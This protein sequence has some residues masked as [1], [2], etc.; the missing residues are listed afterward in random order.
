VVGDGGTFFDEGD[1]CALE[2]VGLTLDSLDMDMKT[3][4][5]YFMYYRTA[6]SP[7]E[8]LFIL[9]PTDG[10]ELSEGALRVEAIGESLGADILTTFATLPLSDVVYSRAGAEYQLSRRADPE[11]IKLLTSLVGETKVGEVPLTAENDMITGG[12]VGSTRRM[13]LSQTRNKW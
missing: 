6:A 1:R 4:R 12:S 11:E 2:A 8:K 3:A 5:E 7:T 13:N 9:A 10:G